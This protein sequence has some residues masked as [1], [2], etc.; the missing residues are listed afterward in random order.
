MAL[1]RRQLRPGSQEVA[2]GSALWDSV[3]HFLPP[4]SLLVRPTDG[5]SLLQQAAHAGTVPM[6]SVSVPA[7]TNS[8][9]RKTELTALPVGNLKWEQLWCAARAWSCNSSFPC[10]SFWV[11]IFIAVVGAALIAKEKGVHF[12]SEQPHGQEIGLCRRDVPLFFFSMGGCRSFCFTSAPPPFVFQSPAI[13]HKSDSS[14]PETPGH[15]VSNRK[16]P[17]YDVR[18]IPGQWGLGLASGGTSCGWCKLH[19]SAQLRG[20]GTVKS[21]MVPELS[22][23]LK[24]HELLIG[25]PVPL[26]SPWGS[27][28]PVQGAPEWLKGLQDF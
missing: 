13:S 27:S 28:Q 17:E 4:C 15:R 6:G 24:K 10:Q 16:A 14:R 9:C 5:T 1:Q 11:C 23:A 18:N 12:K 2:V 26:S 19:D 20:R 7:A 3:L 8:L 21:Q 25:R 22:G